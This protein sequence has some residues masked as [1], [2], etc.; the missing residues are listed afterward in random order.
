MTT[1]TFRALVVEEVADGEFTRSI[2]ERS[3][4]DLPAGEV[5]VRVAWSSLNF[6]DALSATGNKGVTRRYP[7]TPGIDAAGEVVTCSSDAFSPGDQVVVTGWDLGMD[8]PGGFGQYIRVPEA[9]V[10]ALPEG[11]TPRESMIL[12][13]AGFTAAMSVHRITTEVSPSRGEVLVTGAT[14]GVG[15]LAVKLLAQLGYRVVAVSGKPDAVDFLKGLGA[16]EIIDREEAARAHDRP[17]LR[18]RW[19]G[20]VDTVGGEILAAAIKATQP[21]GVVTACGLVASAELP[22]NVFPFILRGVTLVGI[23]SANC[24]RVMRQGLWGRL[25][26]DWKLHDLEALTREVTLDGLEPM[27]QD[28]LRGKLRGR[29]LVKLED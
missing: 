10:L 19:A 1:E 9:W 21:L 18:P 5:L 20:V 16:A 29:T 12:G 26:G 3:L 8:T 13:T 17:L 15:S 28:I 14:G 27:I 2:Q 7:H 25:A 4:D 6:K 11:M 23:D 22:L 24:P